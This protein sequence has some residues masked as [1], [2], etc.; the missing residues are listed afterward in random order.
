V[1]RHKSTFWSCTQKISAD[2]NLAIRKASF[3]IWSELGINQG[4]IQ[5]VAR[6]RIASGRFGLFIIHGHVGDRH[7]RV[8]PH[9]LKLAVHVHI[10]DE[11]DY[12]GIWKGRVNA[13]SL[14]ALRMFSSHIPAS[15]RSPIRRRH[16]QILPGAYQCCSRSRGQCEG[17]VCDNWYI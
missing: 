7:I 2:S 4:C 14:T 12:A 5:I 10:A 16:C 17:S 13:F 9:V 1:K 15:P 11:A 6:D 8:T 3:G